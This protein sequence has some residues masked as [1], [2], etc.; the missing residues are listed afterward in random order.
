[1]PSK[2]VTIS[3]RISHE[4]AEFISQ[5]EINDAKTPSDKLRAVIAEARRRSARKMDYASS[6]QMVQEI[7]LPVTQKIREKEVENSVHSEVLTRLTE[8]VPDALAF[9]ISFTHQTDTKD[10]HQHML[11]LEQGL[12]ERL[13]RL[14]ESFLQLAI[15]STCPCYQPDIIQTNISPVLELCEVISSRQHAEKGV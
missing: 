1:M 5:L 10:E 4:D 14:M 8:W 9:L 7:I 3:A 13:F 15:S 11:Q 12:V 6:L 2:Q